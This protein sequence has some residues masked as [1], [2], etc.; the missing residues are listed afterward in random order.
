MTLRAAWLLSLASLAV[1]CGYPAPN[2]GLNAESQDPQDMGMFK[3]PSLRNVAVT[4]PYMHDGSI[5]SLSEVLD[6]YA[7]GGR[8]ITTG[9]GAGVG[10]KSPLKDPLVRRFEMSEQERLDV[11][12]FLESLTD[13][14]F[15]TNPS[16]ADPWQ[17]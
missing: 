1:A 10:S 3:V 9:P 14:S 13:Q 6:H 15:L 5:L 17:Q 4:A 11:I 8:T 2:T 12:A 16:F 7:A